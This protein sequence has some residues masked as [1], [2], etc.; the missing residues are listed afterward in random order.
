MSG[1]VCAVGRVD[2]CIYFGIAAVLFPQSGIL[3]QY[4][5]AAHVTSNHE[6]CHVQSEWEEALCLD[7]AAA[8][9][10]HPRHHQVAERRRWALGRR[11]HRYSQDTRGRR[12]LRLGCCAGRPSLLKVSCWGA[13]KTHAT[14][15]Q[16]LRCVSFVT[17]AVCS[18]A[19]SVLT[20][21]T[22]FCFSS[23]RIPGAVCFSLFH[24]K[25]MTLL[26]DTFGDSLLECA[27][28]LSPEVHVACRCAAQVFF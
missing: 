21:F 14:F 10:R 15:S 4:T 26:A 19:C 27:H 6:T 28:F 5:L 22:M 9:Q 2:S 13:R 24:C 25:E 11:S 1:V 17:E 16:S 18:M 20:C 8:A 7:V 12:L 23:R 3:F